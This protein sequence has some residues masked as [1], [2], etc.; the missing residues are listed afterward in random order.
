MITLNQHDITAAINDRYANIGYC[1]YFENKNTNGSNELR[2]EITINPTAFISSFQANIDNVVFVGQTKEK[3]IAAS[4]YKDAKE[5]NVNTIL[6]SQPYKEIP[7]VF[8]IKTNMKSKSKVILTIKIEQYLQKQFDFVRLGVE[9]LRNF[10]KYNICTDNLHYISFKLD[11]KDNNGMSAVNIP[12]VNNNNMII[13]KHMT[14]KMGKQH[15]ICGKIMSKSSLN[16]L[17][18]E[19]KI[20]ELQINSSNIIFDANTN[21][22][23][24][25][26]CASNIATNL[27]YDIR[28]RVIFLIDRSGSMNGQKWNKTI[29]A[30]ICA[31]KLLRK[32]YDRFSIILF[33]KNIE[34]L[35]YKDK[36]SNQCILAT[37]ESIYDCINILQNKQVNSD[38]NI[39][40]GLLKGI[41]LI[42]SDILFNQ[43][44]Y[45]HN[46][47]IL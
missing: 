21:T 25:T 30:T 13:D 45:F 43:S 4:E 44:K 23:C 29:S 36:R 14:D 9:I 34:I 39:Q 41:E 22:F 19:Y 26:I 12:T 40:R 28:R 32:K 42:K 16:E 6:I 1:F 15:Y 18:V 7:N 8:E 3:E 10:A 2:F 17:I 37:D 24:H 27:R 47:L 11:I 5:H 38:T 33:D 31:L 35:P 20:K 46:Q